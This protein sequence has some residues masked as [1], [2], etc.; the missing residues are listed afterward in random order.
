M[1]AGR[2]VERLIASWLAEEAEVRSPDR[3]LE[4]A[5]QTIDRTMQRRWL[6]AWREPVTFSMTKLAAIAAAL[7]LALAGAAWIGRS[8]AQDVGGPSGSLATAPSS[9][10]TPGT[11]PVSLES[12]K[13][14]RDEIC[15]RYRPE[16]NPLK[17]DVMNLYDPDLSEADRADKVVAL[18]TA[19]DTIEAM[20]DELRRL[21]APSELAAEHRDD[22]A[23]WDAQVVL[24]HA[25]L[26]KIDEQ[27]LAGAEADDAAA[28]VFAERIAAYESTNRF[29]ACP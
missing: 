22:V 27:D 21:A 29:L 25:A 20:A 2:D 10:A 9:I 11:P 24:F 12:Y 5:R 17:I 16:L 7:V 1:N 14:A 23:N 13:A 8:T 18:A 26:T 19:V 28:D 15:L 4:S 6:A 3:V